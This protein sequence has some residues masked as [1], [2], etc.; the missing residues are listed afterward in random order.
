[1]GAGHLFGTA[2]AT[3]YVFSPFGLTSIRSPIRT[4][5]FAHAAR[6]SRSRYAEVRQEWVLMRTPERTAFVLASASPLGGVLSETSV[7]LH[8][9]GEPFKRWPPSLTDGPHSKMSQC[10]FDRERLFLVIFRRPS[11]RGER[12]PACRQIVRNPSGPAPS[13]P[14]RPVRPNPS[15]LRVRCRR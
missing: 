5:A 9:W 15:S 11:K 12:Y 4:W 2:H 14:R 1:M 10:A 7:L 13:L 3:G 6:W 8:T